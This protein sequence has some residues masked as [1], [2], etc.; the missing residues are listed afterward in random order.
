MSE[1]ITK[2]P[3]VA[4]QYEISQAH[5]E[6]NSSDSDITRVFSPGGDP[7]MPALGLS[8]DNRP[9]INRAEETSKND[10]KLKEFSIGLEVIDEAIFYYFD[11]IIKPAVISNGSMVSVPVLY[12]SGE[13]WKLAQKDGF[14]RDKSG[15]IQTPLVMVKR[16]S[17]EKRR[18]LGNKLDANNPQLFVSYQEKYTKKNQYDSFDILNNRIPQRELSAVVVPDYINITYS[19][20]IWT[21][22]MSQLNKIVEAINYASDAYWGDPERFKFMATIDQFTNINELTSDDNRIVRANFSLN[23]QGYIVP[24]NLQKKLINYKL[25][26]S[27]S[28]FVLN[29]TTTILE[30]PTSSKRATYLLPSQ[31]YSFTTNGGNTNAIENDDWLIYDTYIQNKYGRN[32]V[33]DDASLSLD[34]QDKGG[35]IFLV[36]KQNETFLKVNNDG[37]F[38]LKNFNN[39]PSV[40]EGGIIIKNNELFV[41]L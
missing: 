32:V 5:I 39:F 33:I 35:D 23:L 18:D 20:I 11:N 8:P 40:V 1:R 36:K 10:S 38:S 28:Q 25:G 14:Y 29:Q 21:D 6:N 41:G 2:K 30:D 31:N 16:E 9:H 19:G 27:K 24:E 34:I 26:Y 12:G 7:T 22:Y 13:R 3:R 37:V 15:K 4:R 17:I